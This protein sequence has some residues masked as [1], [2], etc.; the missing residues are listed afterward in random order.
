ML[1]NGIKNLLD[2]ICNSA[3]FLTC[4]CIFRQLKYQISCIQVVLI[5]CCGSKYSHSMIAIFLW[6]VIT[7][8]IRFLESTVTP[9]QVLLFNLRLS[10]KG[11]F[12]HLCWLYDCFAHITLF[13]SPT[14][15]CH[16]LLLQ[17]LN[18]IEK[19]NHLKNNSSSI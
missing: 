11:N 2:G 17:T 13:P 7:L 4:I 16:S 6:L 3:F 9:I 15:A 5:F 18:W 8:A 19:L 1:L 10:L 12:Q 14:C